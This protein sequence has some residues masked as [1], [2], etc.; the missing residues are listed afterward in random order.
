MTANT[1]HLFLRL[2]KGLLPLAIIGLG[3]IVAI[4]FMKTRPTVSRSS[5]KPQPVPVQV[6]TAQLENA[7]VTVTS[8]GTVVPSREITL[9]AQV[10]GKV[11]AMADDFLPGG[12][13]DRDTE[14]LRIDP[15]DYDIELDKKES[16][17]ARARADLRL[18]EGQ[19][20]VARQ[21]FQLLRDS[22]EASL[23]ESDLALRRPQL[24][25]ARADLSSALADL[26]QARLNLSRTVVTAPFN[27]LI[28]ERNVNLGSLVSSQDD[29]AT[30]VSIDEYWVE[31]LVPLGRLPFLDLQQQ[32]GCSVEIV[33]QTG[34][35]TWSGR[36]LR[37]T[38]T[39]DEESRMAT[40]LISVSDPLERGRQLMLGDYVAA[41][42]QGRVLNDVVV[43]PRS[44]LR[45]GDTVWVHVQGRLRM[46]Q[47]K[48]GWKAPEVV[49]LSSGIEPGQQ[50]VTSDLPTPVAGMRISVEPEPGKGE[51][52][53]SPAPTQWRE[54]VSTRQK[55]PASSGK[56][57]AGSGTEP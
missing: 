26:D 41:V 46:Q 24:L 15:R 13:I 8:M 16:A 42:I 44:A 35:G 10:S 39:V 48:V 9:Q 6:S 54:S 56:A 23:E 45:Q 29:L 20:D 14:L 28:T 47:V 57:A 22:S 33:S 7:T 37:L 55:G 34:A 38:G 30:L 5:P 25:Q 43:L 21:E 18:E 36:T 1:T 51:S 52:S 12:R 31:V 4:S 11:V 32:G 50:V 49:Y 17:V 27:A 2:G 3:I 53:G 19:Q 40:V